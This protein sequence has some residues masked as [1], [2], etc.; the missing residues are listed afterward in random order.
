MTIRRSAA[1]VLFLL[2]FFD[3]PTARAQDSPPD[4]GE[5][6]PLVTVQAQPYARARAEFQTRL[7]HRGPAPEPD[8]MPPTPDGVTLVTYPSGKLR[9]H[10]WIKRPVA[11][12]S[13]R[14]PAILFVH[15]GFSFG[16]HDW[17]MAQPFLDAGYVVMTPTLRGENRQAG[18]FTLFY[19]E[20]DD[21][22]AAGKWL[23]RQPGVASARSPSWRRWRH[24]CFA[25]PHRS[26]DRPIR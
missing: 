17:E 22:I 8:S 19:D 25:A 26:P 21:V 4:N 15:G 2:A 20:V 7:V 16:P 11:A 6:A 18:A 23:A 14:R 5:L 10:A 3:A 1:H 9:L 13:A 24:R 12:S